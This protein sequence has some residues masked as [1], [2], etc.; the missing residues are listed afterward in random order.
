[1]HFWDAPESIDAVRFYCLA[2]DE[3][4]KALENL[5]TSKTRTIGIT[6]VSAVSLYYKAQEFLQAKRISHTALSTNM[7]YSLDKITNY[8]N[9]AIF[10]RSK[11]KSS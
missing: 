2:A 9:E 4:V 7:G 3:E 8:Y 6:V 10:C 11:R 1:V 5:D